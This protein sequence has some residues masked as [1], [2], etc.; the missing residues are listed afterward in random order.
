M[1]TQIL[2]GLIYDRL[3]WSKKEE[4]YSEPEEYNMIKI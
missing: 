4:I 1:F 2:S 3:Q